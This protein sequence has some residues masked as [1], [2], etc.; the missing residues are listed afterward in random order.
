VYD[1]GTAPEDIDTTLTQFPAN[2]GPPIIN[3]P[4]R[5]IYRGL[6]PT[7]LPPTAAQDRVEVVQFDRPGIFLVICAVLPHF[8]EGM[9]GYVRVVPGKTEDD[10]SL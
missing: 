8:Q 4:E 2:G 1:D 5:R 10:D 7:L 3:D 9:Y 6:D